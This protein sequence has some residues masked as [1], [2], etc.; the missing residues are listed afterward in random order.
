MASKTLTRSIRWDLRKG[1]RS[2]RVSFTVIKG[3]DFR[4]LLSDRLMEGD[5]LIEVR[6]IQVLLSMRIFF[7]FRIFYSWRCVG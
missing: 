6:L 1:D 4:A 5:R 7:L 3:N 2:M